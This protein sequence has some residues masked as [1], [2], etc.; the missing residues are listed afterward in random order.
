MKIFQKIFILSVLFF[1]FAC[2]NPTNEEIE[3]RISKSDGLKRVNQFCM[4][5]PKPDNIRFVRKGIISN[6]I[7]DAI[8]FRYESYDKLDKIWMFYE[9][10]A[11]ENDWKLTE[12]DRS[13]NL[14]SYAKGN[15][16]IVIELGPFGESNFIIGCKEKR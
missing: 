4:Q 15:Q 10:W 13:A 14:T 12:G 16:T 1:S 2:D 9:N 3:V 11:K 6:S 7:N 5:L 8:Q